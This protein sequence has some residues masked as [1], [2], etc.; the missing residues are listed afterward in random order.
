MN[1]EQRLLRQAE[2]SVHS[3]NES[4]EK[5]NGKAEMLIRVEG[6]GQN[7]SHTQSV[8]AEPSF[9]EEYN[10]VEIPLE[11]SA[12]EFSPLTAAYYKQAKVKRYAELMGI[13]P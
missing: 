4:S 13:Q 12:Q 8:G 3:R 9:N 11:N 10:A 5:E 6:C 1:M 2:K 7:H